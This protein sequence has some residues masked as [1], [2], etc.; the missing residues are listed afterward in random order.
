MSKF[1]YEDING[2]IILSIFYLFFIIIGVIKISKFYL[3]K[4]KKTN[5]ILILST[6]YLYIIFLIDILYK[7]IPISPDSNF[8]IKLI[9][10]DISEIN[11]PFSYKF[12]GYLNKVFSILSFNKIEFWV[13]FNIFISYFMIFNYWKAWLNYKENNVSKISQRIYIILILLYPS[14][15][16]YSLSPL[17]E[18][19][20]ALS[21]SIFFNGL[22]NKKMNNFNIYLGILLSLLIRSQMSIILVS[23]IAIKIFI[24]M[25]KKYKSQVIFIGI[26]FIFGITK[27][28]KFLFKNL[29]YEYTL[30]GIIKL[31]NYKILAHN[32]PNHTYPLIYK[33]SIIDILIE[34]NKLV[35]Q[36]ML[37]PFSILKKYYDIGLF[38]KIDGIFVIILFIFCI[39]EYLKE[40][41]W[42]LYI[43]V[44]I[45]INSFYEFHVTGAVRHRYIIIF[46]IIILISQKFEKNYRKIKRGK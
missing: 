28:L 33:N 29:S 8:Y 34:F 21:F 44:L 27:I 25:L 23:I 18:N 31:R 12:Y 30:Q 5:Q 20:I 16:N 10:E 26:I 36:F 46:L 17:R 9:F 39:K 38:M 4:D 41:E 3:L 43:F 15:L 1:Y 14:F 32:L 24:K 45:M 19:Y 6:I 11:I 35:F 7:I 2:I 22:T 13:L 37:A 42:S 40:K